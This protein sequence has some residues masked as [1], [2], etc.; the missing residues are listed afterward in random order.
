[1]FRSALLCCF[2]TA[3][4]ACSGNVKPVAQPAR[5]TAKSV[6]TL[7]GVMHFDLAVTQFVQKGEASARTAIAGLAEKQPMNAEQRRIFDELKEQMVGVLDHEFS[8]DRFGPIVVTTIQEAYNQ[9]DVDAL[10]SIF[11]SPAGQEAATQLELAAQDLA[12]GFM[13]SSSGKLQ[14][15]QTLSEGVETK[16]A[17]RISPSAREAFAVFAKTAVGQDIVA[18]T[19]AWQAR[20][21]E[22]VALLKAD[23]V[24]RLK[25]LRENYTVRIKAASA[26]K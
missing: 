26:A 7:L 17:N 22:Q 2:I 3:L 5:P 8:W 4:S 10:V 14:E 11:E 23:S 9:Q 16:L 20:Y 1:M 13:R 21:D 25:A 15:R 18:R 24:E 6:R 19:P 12:S